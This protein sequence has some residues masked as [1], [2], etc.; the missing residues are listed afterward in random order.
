[1]AQAFDTGT[2]KLVGEPYVVADPVSRIGSNGR[3]NVAVS[4]TGLLLYSDSNTL[5]QFTWFDTA[6]KPL[7]VVG[8]PDDNGPFRLSHDGRLVAVSRDR[9]GWQRSLAAGGGARGFQTIHEFGEQSL[10]CLVPRRSDDCVPLRHFAEPVSQG[11][12]RRRERTT[13]HRIAEQPSC[14]GLVTRRTLCCIP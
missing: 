7:G 4:A 3:M 14:H 11:V 2:L 10:P 6:G 13:P 8:E 1:M 12:E 9:P 5:S